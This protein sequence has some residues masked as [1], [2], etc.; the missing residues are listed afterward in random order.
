M[1]GFGNFMVTVSGT[2]SSRQD[3]LIFGMFL[4]TAIEAIASN[5]AVLSSGTAGQ[6][7]V[8]FA[9]HVAGFTNDPGSHFIGGSDII[10]APGAIVLVS[11]GA[12]LVGWLR[13]KRML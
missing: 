7:N 9:A 4:P 12:G 3:P 10:P 2:G 1:D 11:V 8:F 5:F 6:G 13:R